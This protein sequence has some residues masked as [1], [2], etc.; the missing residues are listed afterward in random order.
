[1]LHKVLSHISTTHEKIEDFA[2]TGEFVIG[3]LV[4]KKIQFP[5]GIHESGHHTNPSIDMDSDLAKPMRM[6][7]QGKAGTLVIKDISQIQK[8]S[9]ASGSLKYLTSCIKRKVDDWKRD[10]QKAYK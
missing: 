9:Q 3:R 6:A 10:V 4:G 8:I 2:D 5:V 7:L 1:L